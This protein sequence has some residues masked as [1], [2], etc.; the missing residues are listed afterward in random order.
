MRIMAV[1][2]SLLI[3]IFSCIPCGDAIAA[4]ASSNTETSN[5][6]PVDK[7]EHSDHE[8]L[9]SPFCQCACCSTV[10]VLH[11]PLLLSHSVTF[12]DRQVYSGYLPKEEIEISL[13]VWQPPQL[14]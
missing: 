3:L 7:S 14:V 6:A 1:I 11:T 10:S 8:D 13:P 5:K 4:Q 12:P 9:C 2:L